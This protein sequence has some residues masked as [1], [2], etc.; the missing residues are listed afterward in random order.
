MTVFS[1]RALLV[2]ITTISLVGGCNY[3]TPTVVEEITGPTQI[4]P[5]RGRVEV[6]NCNNC[7]CKQVWIDDYSCRC[8]K[9]GSVQLF[10]DA[11]GVIQ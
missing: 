2:V 1:V 6:P 3:S 7:E 4:P 9:C 11:V 8:P 10:P 5:F